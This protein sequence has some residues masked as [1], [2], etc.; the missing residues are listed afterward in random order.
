MIQKKQGLNKK[1]LSIIITS[2]V[3]VV[4]ITAYVLLT[5]IL[6]GIIANSGGNKKDP[7]DILEEIGE[8]LYSNKAIVYP[9][10]KKDKITSITVGSHVDKFSM[11][12]PTDKSDNTKYLDYFIFYYEDDNG[13]FKEYFPNISSTDVDFNY[14]DLYSKEESD[15]LG[16]YKIDYLCAAVGALFFDERIALSS[17]PAEKDTQLNRYGLGKEEKE[18]IIIGYVDSDGKD[19]EYRIHIGDK[20][21]TGNGYYFMIDGRD[22]V[23][24]SS[25]SNT[26]SY[27]LG[28]FEEFLHSRIIAAELEGDKGAAPYHTKNYSQWTSV[29]HKLTGEKIPAGVEVILNADC[30]QPI[31]NDI[32]N[33]GKEVIGKGTGYRHSGY[34]NLSFD[35]ASLGSSPEFDR[36]I[37]YL[38]GKEIGELDAEKT[39]TVLSDLNQA[40]LYDEKTNKGIYEYTIYEIE[41]LLTEDGE[42]NEKGTAISSDSIIKVTYG[43]KL[44]GVA[45]VSEKTHAVIDLGKAVAIP[46]DV[47]SKLISSG[48]GVLSDPESCSFEVKYNTDNVNKR[49][50]EYVITNISLICEKDD[51]GNANYLNKVTDKSIVTYTFHYLLDG[52]AVGAGDIVTIDLS[53]VKAGH[54]LNVKNA[55]VGKNAGSQSIS[56]ADDVY[57]QPFMDFRSYNIKSLL[58]YVEMEATVAFKYLP[59]GERDNFRG[60]SMYENILT[61]SV[62]S[63]Y[64]IND[65]A[66]DAVLRIVGGINADAGS[67][68]A[69]GV[70]GME[71]VA[72]GL[73][74]EN[75]DKYGLYNGHRISFSLPRGLSPASTS[76]GYDWVYDLEF[77][78]YVGE[79]QPDGTRYVGSEM[80]DIVVKIDA[81][82]FDYLDYSFP[83]Y[84]ARRNLVMINV[85]NINKVGVEFSMDKLYGKY[86]LEVDH[87]TKYYDENGIYSSKPEGNDYDE[88]D[89]IDVRVH[90]LG[91]RHSDSLL[92]QIFKDQK[93]QTTGTNLATVYNIAAGIKPGSGR[94]GLSIGFDTLGTSS[95]KDVMKVMFSTYYLGVLSEEDQAKA[96]EENR[97]LRVGFDVE[98]ASTFTYTYDFHRIDDRRVLVSLYRTDFTGQKLG[99]VRDFYISTPAFK[100]IVSNFTNLFNGVEIDSEI[101]Y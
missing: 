17:D 68:G 4:L 23:Y 64:M 67:S 57:C 37:K 19:S 7:P 15:G 29:Y 8:S 61:D 46:A 69:E 94:P 51:K 59:E 16:M 63:D 101:P 58:G 38:V 28:G 54:Y 99:E 14:T 3:L 36:M 41:A 55:L 56:V 95:F 65:E 43:F 24:A 11:V 71:T 6:P 62:Y 96:T 66:C 74:H 60:E 22:Y 98:G 92:M 44:D 49:K 34:T 85:A 84:W 40:V 27:A 76:Q 42:I 89:F 50:M 77:V 13:K 18:T 100:K 72:V 20:L 32:E 5:A 45:P 73:N 53:K 9:Y 31:Y 26:L 90:P 83:E 81:S 47:K 91:D 78:L 80:Y 88:Y 86:D 79:R 70:V 2:A 48:V 97:L 75:M 25:G 33:E 87:T 1:H 82:V 30:M 12:R 39:V 21:I 10:L 35:L 52:E 93:D